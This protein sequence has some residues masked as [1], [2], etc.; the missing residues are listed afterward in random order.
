MPEAYQHKVEVIH[1]GIDTDAFKRDPHAPR[2]LPD[3]T[4]IDAGTRIV[5]YATR[6]FEMI[7]GFDTFMKAAKL[8]YRHYPDV[9][10]VVAGTDRVCYG[11]ESQRAGEASFRERVLKQ[12]DFDLSRFRFVGKV[13]Q[14]A[15]ARLLSISDLHVY[16]T[17]PFFTSW[18]VLEAM[19]SGCV[20]LASDQSCVR[21]YLTHGVNGLLCGFLD[22][23]ELARQAVA[24]L[25]DPGA[26]RPLADAARRT[27]EQTYSID[28]TLPKIKKMFERVAANGPRMPSQRAEGLVQPRAPA[29][30]VAAPSGVAPE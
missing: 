6:G 17:A 13:P 20:V 15:L 5:T 30:P 8:I 14:A 12:G 1:D 22:A 16:L 4:S 23:E 9:I 27:I 18:S 28:A 3:G 19:S 10:F 7:R 2:C 26:H 11:S 24:V 25:T 29:R 21:Q